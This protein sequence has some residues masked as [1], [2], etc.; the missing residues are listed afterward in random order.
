VAGISKLPEDR[1]KQLNT[2]RAQALAAAK[3]FVEACQCGDVDRF[4]AAA[5]LVNDNIQPRWITSFRHIALLG[6]VPKNIQHEFQLLWFESRLSSYCVCNDTLLDALHV[7]FIPY[8]GPSVRLFR[9]ANAREARVRKFYG[10]SW[11]SDIEEA[12]WFARH[13][14]ATSGGTVVLETIA[15]PEAIISAPGIDGVYYEGADGQRLFDEREYIVDGR[16]LQ[17][18]TITRRYPEISFEEWE[19]STGQR[20][21]SLKP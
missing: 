18:V 20:E 11:S 10:P 13:W 7:L 4:R 16:R 14:Q 15:P 8:K 9:G 1:K 5:G 19:K 12:D 17:R 6:S 21:L 3:V 2:E